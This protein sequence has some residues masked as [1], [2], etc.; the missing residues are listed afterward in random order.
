MTHYLSPEER[1]AVIKT[2]R[3]FLPTNGVPLVDFTLQACVPC[4]TLNFGCGLRMSSGNYRG[5]AELEAAGF[6]VQNYDVNGV[7][8]NTDLLYELVFANCVLN[9]LPSPEAI[10]ATLR[11]TRSRLRP[12]GLILASVPFKPRRVAAIEYVL[13]Q[14]PGSLVRYSSTMI[15]MERHEPST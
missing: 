12:G 6:R 1:R 5:V 15:Y 3:S 14:E 8:C 11:D 10:T 13:Q 7:E 4:S 9:V 2:A